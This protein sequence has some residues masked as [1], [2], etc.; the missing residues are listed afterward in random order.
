MIRALTALGAGAALRGRDARVRTLLVAIA[1]G[2]AV[3]LLLLAVSVPGALAARV[4]RTDARSIEIA[5]PAAG[6][7]IAA[8]VESGLGSAGVSGIVVAPPAASA[9]LPPGIRALP[10]SGS[11]LVSPGLLADLRG[12]DRALLKA[13]LP[14]RIAGTIGEAGL[15]GPGESRFVAVDPA[16]SAGGTAVGVARFGETPR[17]EP[18]DPILSLLV[19]VGVLLLLVPIGI[20]VAVAGRFGAERRDRRLA[21]LRLLGLSSRHVLA[22]ALLEAVIAAAI[23]D[24]LGLAVFAAARQGVGAVTIATLSVFPGDIVPPRARARARAARRAGAPRRR[25]RWP[26][27]ARS[28]S[29]RS[30]SPG[31][32][33]A[34]GASSGASSR[35]ATAVV[36]LAGG[37]ALTA[38]RIPLGTWVVGAGVALLLTAAVAMLP[39]L[40]ERV[41]GSRLATGP[42]SWQVALRRI[43]HDGT[44]TGRVV[45][46]VT[47]VVAG[48]IALQLLFAGLEGS[49]TSQTGVTATGTELAASSLS[50]TA[51]ERMLTLFQRTPGG[52]ALAQTDL[53]VH[54]H[55]DRF[56]TVLTGDCRTL[57]TVARISGCQEGSSYLVPGG[58]ARAGAALDAAG[59]W[60][61]PAE[62][63]ARTTLRPLPT[64]GSYDGVVLVTR[65]ALPLARQGG[66][67]VT[68]LLPDRSAALVPAVRAA[69]AIDP[70]LQV[71]P[72]SPTS[73]S[74]RFDTVRRGLTVGLVLVLLLIGLVLLVSVGEQLRER[75]RSLAVLAV[76]GMPRAVL[77]RSVL[78]ESGV[79]VVLGGAVAAVTGAA[80]GTALLAI[81]G[82]FA[83]PDPGVV[84][85]TAVVALVV[86]LL[87]TAAS[88]PAALRLLRPEHLRAE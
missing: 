37:T 44:T 56:V 36:L 20:V 53:P 34:V 29:S 28:G 59:M 40:T 67:T 71:Q 1:S 4:A 15:A 9:P 24:L 58:S 73:T 84:L 33:H 51:A 47:A 43:R 60:P 52:P 42:V 86:P 85:S 17:P 88:L 49:Y 5:D 74:H 6:H 70:A 30:G 38:A 55:P 25:R 16:L 41:A 54:G 45:G 7:L 11:M 83:L 61:L 31:A 72:L 79:P 14:Y 81:V 39:W 13:R 32:P 23:G 64:A 80:L 68:T 50:G 48:A 78:A 82:R 62:P 57:A 35:S 27:S 2:F 18:L 63:A 26:A 3:A 77:V 65:S 21:A 8:D 76:I 10:P 69:T 66:V 19:V 12:P 46:A 87:V 75:R 22:L